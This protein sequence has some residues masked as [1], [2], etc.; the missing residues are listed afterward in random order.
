M[1]IIVILQLFNTIILELRNFTVVM[2]SE[3]CAATNCTKLGTLGCT[4]CPPPRTRYCSP[5]CRKQDWKN[6]KQTCAGSQKYNCFLIHP[7]ASSSESQ[8]SSDIDCI[9]PFN[10]ESY[11]DWGSEMSELCERLGWAEA[12]EGGKFYSHKGDDAWYYYVYSPP[13]PAETPPP[14]NEVASRCI[15]KTVYGDIAVVRSGPTE[16]YRFPKRFS[17]IELFF[18]AEFYKTR[19]PRQIFAEREQTRF[20]KKIGLPEGFLDGVPA[21]HFEI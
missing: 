6:H 4:G 16:S 12:N 14:R 7:L 5:D 21:C 8:E 3:N 9:E 1:Y 20:G 2:S 18:T 11:G 10:L 19:D 13:I 17:K 15:G